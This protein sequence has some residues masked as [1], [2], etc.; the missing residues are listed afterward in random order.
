MFHDHWIVIKIQKYGQNRH[1]CY[2]LM[3]YNLAFWQEGEHKNYLISGLRSCG[4]E[5][6]D[7]QKDCGLNTNES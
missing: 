5:A 7:C 1:V 6:Q 2:Y 3:I 4:R